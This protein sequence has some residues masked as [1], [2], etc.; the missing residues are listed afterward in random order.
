MTHLRPQPLAGGCESKVESSTAIERFWAVVLVSALGRTLRTPEN[1]SLV[2][3]QKVFV[4]GFLA[5]QT[6]SD[7]YVPTVPLNTMY[8][9]QIVPWLEGRGVK[10][11]RE[12]RVRQ[13]LFDSEE[14]TGIEMADGKTYAFDHVIVA[15]PWK[16][17]P[18]LMP[19]NLVNQMPELH[20]NAQSITGSPITSVHLWFD[21]PVMDLPHAV[22]VGRLS[23]WV[24]HHGENYYQVVI[25]ASRELAGRDREGILAEVLADLCAIWP[26]AAKAKLQRSHMVTQPD[27][28]FSVRPGLD[29]IRPGQQTGIGNFHLAGD[30]TRTGWPSTMEGA[31]ISGRLAADGVLALHRNQ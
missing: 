3:A 18:S 7:L 13:L 1:A 20:A 16:R 9:K 14:I 5:S 21:S 30:W 8:E 2:A 27:A 22:L 19:P 15:V 28:V 11:Y 6:A 25:S 4:D 10:V 24:F 12:S 23:Q 17:L 31:V 26:Q 29:R